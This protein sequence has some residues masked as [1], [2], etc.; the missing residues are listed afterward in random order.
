MRLSNSASLSLFA[1]AVLLLACLPASI[2]QSQSHAPYKGQITKLPA[3][4]GKVGKAA[5]DDFRH[6]KEPPKELPNLPNFPGRAKYLYGLMKSKG[7]GNSQIGLHYG[8]NEDPQSVLSFY[9]DSLMRYGWKVD[10]PIDARTVSATRGG[11]SVMIRLSPKSRP[12]YSTDFQISYSMSDS[13]R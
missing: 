9:K 6:L 13:G 8:T 7:S 2:A 3:T 4:P 11:C 5:E 10:K 1:T 12:E